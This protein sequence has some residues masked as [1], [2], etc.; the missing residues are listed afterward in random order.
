MEGGKIKEMR[1][2]Q[3]APAARKTLEVAA[4]LADMVAAV[5]AAVAIA[6]AA[7]RMALPDGVGQLRA[8]PLAWDPTAISRPHKIPTVL[9]I[10]ATLGIRHPLGI[11]R[12]SP[13]LR[14]Y[15]PPRYPP[16]RYLR[17]RY[18]PLRYLLQSTRGERL[19]TALGAGS[20]IRTQRIRWIRTRRT[21]LRHPYSRG[22]ST[23]WHDG[24]HDGS[25]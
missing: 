15:L 25:P 24:S 2:A 18:L 22:C 13:R 7:V 8:D 21:T 20:G 10:W 14:R 1:E 19:T 11:R 6:L 3:A 16:P 4:V 17:R 9:G 5:A 12:A 23:L